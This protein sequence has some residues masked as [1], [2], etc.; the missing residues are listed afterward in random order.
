MTVSAAQIFAGDKLVDANGRPTA[1]K[2]ID[3]EGNEMILRRDAVKALALFKAAAEVD[4]VEAAYRTA[5]LL[6]Q[7][8]PLL[9]APTCQVTAELQRMWMAAAARGLAFSVVVCTSLV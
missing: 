1:I 4:H 5:D 3:D 7:A 8:Q 2:R 6:V 9:D